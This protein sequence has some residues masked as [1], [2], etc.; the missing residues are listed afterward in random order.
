MLLFHNSKIE[1]P[2]LSFWMR[3]KY[4]CCSKSKNVWESGPYHRCKKR[5]AFGKN[6]SKARPLWFVSYYKL[7]VGLGVD[8]VVT[9]NFAI[10]TFICVWKHNIVFPA[11]TLTQKCHLFLKTDSLIINW[12]LLSYTTFHTERLSSSGKIWHQRDFKNSNFQTL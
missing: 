6:P 8:S 11:L 4:L 10:Y 1:G 12:H 3:Y 5:I 2:M 9:G 7:L